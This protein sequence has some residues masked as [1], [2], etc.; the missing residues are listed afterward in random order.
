MA[1]PRRAGGRPLTGAGRVFGLRVA[2]E[3]RPPRRWD[4]APALMRA[5]SMNVV[6]VGEFAWSRLALAA[7]DAAVIVEER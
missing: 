7:G 6:R 2:P 5:A 4:E 1:G 3:H